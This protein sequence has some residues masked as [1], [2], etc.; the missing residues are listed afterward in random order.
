MEGSRWAGPAEKR[1]SGR[2]C[3]VG[4]LMG[5]TNRKRSSRRLCDGGRLMGRTRKKK[6]QQVV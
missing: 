4:R 2:L 3:D 5:R 1:S 6:E